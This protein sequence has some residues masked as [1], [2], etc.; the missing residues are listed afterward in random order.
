[1][2]N[3]LIR[4]KK[5]ICGLLP[6]LGLAVALCTVGYCGKPVPSWVS[7]QEKE[8]EVNEGLSGVASLKKGQPEDL[9]MTFVLKGKRLRLFDDRGSV[10]W[11]SDSSYKVQDFLLADLDR[12]GDKELI[13]LLWKRGKYGTSRPFWVTEDETDYSQHLFLYDIEEGGKLQSK[14]FTSDVGT[15]IRRMK[16]LERTPDILLTETVEGV[17][18]LWRWNTWGL[19]YVDNEVKL[20]SFGDNIIHDE[21]RALADRKYNGNYDF[22][23]EHFLEDIR[24]ADIATLQLE[25]ILVDKDSAV[26]GYPDFGSPLSVGTAIREAGFDVAVAGGNH[27]LDRGI[28]GIDVTKGFFDGAGI[29]CVGIQGS[30]DT[31]Y[32]P[33][34]TLEKKGMRIALFSYTYGTNGKDISD[35]YPFAVHY[36]PETGDQERAM[37]EELKAIRQDRVEVSDGAAAKE[38]GGVDFVV[39]FV[40][41]G[42]EYSLEASEKQRH[43][44]QLFS[45]GGADLVIGTHPHVVQDVDVI[46]RGKHKDAAETGPADQTGSGDMGQGQTLVFYSLGNFRACQGQRQETKTGLEAVVTL[47]H[48]YDGV[49]VKTYSS[50]PVDAYVSNN[51]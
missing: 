5:R 28:Y 29:S 32:R 44:A 50:K 8:V 46:D 10:L 26:A 25:S 1:M 7:W 39:V 49:R 12:N 4:Y 17:N 45:E 37:V 15:P 27:A 43:L 11:E 30:G 13:A 42:D 47:E 31:D 34:E 36:L 14:W 3:G 23:Y 16:M 41:W 40:H 18:N 33:C 24:A 21:I 19:E 20:V 2:I 51:G 35:K 9:A 6:A 38:S 22:L 48:T